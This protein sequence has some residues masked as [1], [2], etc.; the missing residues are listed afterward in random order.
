MRDDVEARMD[1]AELAI[2]LAARALCE[3]CGK[4]AA[5][6]KPISLFGPYHLN[7]KHCRD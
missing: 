1:A 2:R 6:G 3:R 5:P 4:P 7:P